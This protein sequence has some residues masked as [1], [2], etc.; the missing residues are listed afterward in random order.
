MFR[1]KRGQELAERKRLAQQPAQ[2]VVRTLPVSWSRAGS[3]SVSHS[4]KTGDDRAGR[5]GVT[6]TGAEVLSPVHERERTLRGR[7]V[8][9]GGYE[10]LTL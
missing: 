6:D 5:T 7:C 10:E 2:A 1:R 3:A 8:E 9:L 4:V